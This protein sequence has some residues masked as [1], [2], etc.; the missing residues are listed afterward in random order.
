MLEKSNA[1]PG[2]GHYENFEQRR[3]LHILANKSAL[4]IGFGRKVSSSL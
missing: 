1:T 4:N 2:P 3:Q